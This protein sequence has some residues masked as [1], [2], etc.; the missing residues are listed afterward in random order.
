MHMNVIG[1]MRIGFFR[2]GAMLT[3]ITYSAWQQSVG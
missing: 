3:L 2:Q 1:T